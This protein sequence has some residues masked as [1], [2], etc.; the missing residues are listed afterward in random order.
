MIRELGAV[1]PLL[2]ALTVGRLPGVQNVAFMA[3]CNLCLTD[4]ATLNDIEEKLADNGCL[5]LLFSALRQH[6]P[7]PQ[8]VSIRVLYGLCQM[9]IGVQDSVK[10][11][12]GVQA[13][14]GA[15]QTDCLE[16]PELL[17]LAM[18]ALYTLF[19]LDASIFECISSNG[20]VELMIRLTASSTE[21]AA[22]TVLLAV[23]IL[24]KLARSSPSCAQDIRDSGGIQALEALR[25]Q[26]ESTAKFCIFTWVPQVTRNSDF[27]E[28]LHEGASCF[29]RRLRRSILC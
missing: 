18:D 23:S 15:L 7:L 16:D 10:D 27:H 22:G 4:A 20:G 1:Q 25:L 13:L 2:D 26:G 19:R 3:L 24:G 14:L 28:N 9:D 8:H 5:R 11:S 29:N 12:G 17:E 6:L 21:A